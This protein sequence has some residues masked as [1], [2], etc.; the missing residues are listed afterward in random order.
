MVAVADEVQFRRLP[1]ALEQLDRL[2]GGRDR[3][4]GGVQKEQRPRR[5]ASDHVV[6]AEVEHALRRLRRKRFDRVAREIA[7]QMRRDRH[8]VVARHHQRLAG[9]GAVLAAFF[10]HSGEARPR[11]RARVLAAEL[12]LAIAP[13]AIGDDRGDARIDTAGIDRD[14]AAEARADHADARGIDRGMLGEKRQRIA[15]VLDLLE[16]DYAAELAFA[17]AAAAHV[18]AQHDVAEFAEHLGGR[19]GVGGGLV[20]AEAVQHQKRAAP[21]GGA[22]SGRQVHHAGELEPGGGKGDGLLGHGWPLLARSPSDC[23]HS[24]AA[25]SVRS[26]SP[27]G[28]GLG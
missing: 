22:H 25:Q 17:L 15:R 11:L 23:K 3:I 18:E 14:R 5:N 26:L 10:E 4:V 9:A 6:G 2:L 16:A 13:A 24:R 19:H 27:P 12:A 1:G 8:D 28:R 21:L 20:A 7:A